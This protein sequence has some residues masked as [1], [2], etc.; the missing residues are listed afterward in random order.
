MV[1]KNKTLIK[2]NTEEENNCVFCYKNVSN[3][4]Y[5]CKTCNNSFHWNCI[6]IYMLINKKN[7]YIN[8]PFCRTPYKN[9]LYNE[10][11]N[12]NLELGFENTIDTTINHEII[13]NETINQEDQNTIWC[14][15]IAIILCILY[16][17]NS[18]FLFEIVF[19]HVHYVEN[20]TNTTTITKDIPY[21][22]VLFYFII[23]YIP[24]KLCIH[25]FH[26]CMSNQIQKIINVVNTIL[27]FF[28]NM[29]LFINIESFISDIYLTIGYLFEIIL[30]FLLL[31]FLYFI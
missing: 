10:I 11:N 6:K 13:N 18:I 23:L 20:K 28:V 8:C 19:S 2:I 1:E 3:R 7:R 30:D 4:I 26:F 21:S 9:I 29:I 12:I 15:K 24:L 31:V 16:F 14:K 22:D 27:T 5:M 17:F 25:M